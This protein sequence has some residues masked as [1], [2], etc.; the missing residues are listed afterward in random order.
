MHDFIDTYSILYDGFHVHVLITQRLTQNV[1]IVTHLIEC[2]ISGG[3]YRHN[4]AAGIVQ[5]LSL[6]LFRFNSN[7]L[8]A[9]GVV[10][11][12]YVHVGHD[13]IVCDTIAEL[14]FML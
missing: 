4:Y 8:P 7:I 14:L 13:L 6:Y 1:C 2:K 3:P 12:L 11:G 9:A 10:A 5:L